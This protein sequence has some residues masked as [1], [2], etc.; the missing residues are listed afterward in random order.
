MIELHLQKLTEVMSTQ[1]VDIIKMRF[2]LN[3]WEPC[4]L[5]EVWVEFWV[6][7]DKIREIEWQALKILK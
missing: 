3:W 4:T 7:R 6:T 2:G 5:E 1:E